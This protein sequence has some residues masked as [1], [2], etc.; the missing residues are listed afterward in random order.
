MISK[1]NFTNDKVI[2]SLDKK[3]KTNKN[4]G[5]KTM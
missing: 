4:C 2:N 1:V 5:Q 3:M